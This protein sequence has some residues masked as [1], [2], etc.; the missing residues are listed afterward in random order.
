[1][2]R[3]LS[4]N[5]ENF[6]LKTKS[7]LKMNSIWERT[8]QHLQKCLFIPPLSVFDVHECI[9]SAHLHHPRGEV[10]TVQHYLHVEVPSVSRQLT[11]EDTS[12]VQPVH[13]YRQCSSSP[14][15]F[16][17]ACHLLHCRKKLSVLHVARMTFDNSSLNH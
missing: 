3:K 10:V 7:T 4:S 17:V 2:G 15:P 11:H 16:P 5:I 9:A 8:F 1:M 6:E 14:L 13:C 12:S